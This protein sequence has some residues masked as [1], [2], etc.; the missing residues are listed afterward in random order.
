[1]F[2]F[3]IVSYSLNFRYVN[4]ILFLVIDLFVFVNV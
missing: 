1:M 3:L 2:E 4:I